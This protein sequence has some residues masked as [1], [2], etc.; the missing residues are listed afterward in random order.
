MTE[1]QIFE[2]FLK[3][4]M[5][6]VKGSAS[7]KDKSPRIAA[8]ANNPSGILVGKDESGR[9]I[10]KQYKSPEEGVSGAESE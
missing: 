4:P 8:D 5:P 6:L 10:Y 1:D 9:P 3:T 7:T 2:S